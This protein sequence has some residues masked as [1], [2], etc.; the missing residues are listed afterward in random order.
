M[1]RPAALNEFRAAVSKALR[2]GELIRPA[3]HGVLAHL[4]ADKWMEIAP[5]IS[6]RP[7]AALVD[8]HRR[9]PDRKNVP[10]LDIAAFAAGREGVRLADVKARFGVSHRTA[11]RMLHRLESH[12]GADTQFD[13]A[14]IKVWHLRDARIPAND[15]PARQKVGAA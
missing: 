3:R 8:P 11:Q 12:F 5:R 15:F 14:G 4:S 2:T 10:F 9:V 7:V 1:T 13:G 6:N